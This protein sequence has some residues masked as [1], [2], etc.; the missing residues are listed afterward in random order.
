MDEDD[1]ELLESIDE[2]LK[3][4]VKLRVQDR[5]DDDATNREKVKLLYNLGM[6]NS[7]MAEIIGTSKSSVRG[8]VSSLRSD[9]E[10]D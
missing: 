4:L 1:R 3:W 8:T 6:S 10:I 9:G 2:Q 7:Q 5:F